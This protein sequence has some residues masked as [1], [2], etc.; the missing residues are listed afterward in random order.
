[1]VKFST[2]EGLFLMRA[3]LTDN[4]WLLYEEVRLTGGFAMAM[5]WKGALAGQFVVSLGGYHPEFEVPAGYPVVPRLG[6]EW[7]ISD[8]I[9]IKGGSYF[10]LTSEALMAGVDVELSANWGWAWV[11]V[12]FGAHAIVFF[13]PFFF[14][15]LAYARISAGIRIKIWFATVS[16]SISIGARIEVEGP[17]FS[18]KATFEIGPCELSVAFGKSDKAKTPPLSWSEF[19][20]KYL[21]DAG[22]DRAR[23]ITGITGRGTRPAATDGARS[24]PS[25]D[26]SSTHPYEVFAEFEITFVTTVPVTRFEAG[27]D[28]V[29]LRPTLSDGTA[30]D[31]GIAPM[32]VSDLG[33][34]MEVTLLRHVPGLNRY[35]LDGGRLAKLADGLGL[36]AAPVPTPHVRADAFPVGVWGPA[37][38]EDQKP[39][40]QG[41]VV[42]AGTSLTLVAG[43]AAAAAGPEIDYRRITSGRRPLPLLVTEAAR[44]ELLDTAGGV[45]VSNPGTPA[46]ALDAART[47]LFA[48]STIPATPGLLARGEHSAVAAA[49]FAG[50]RSAPPRF[51]TLAGGIRRDLAG[52]ATTEP[53]PPREEPTGRTVRAPTVVGLLAAGAGTV[54]EGARTTVADRRRKRRPAPGVES[55]RGRLGDELPIRLDRPAAPARSLDGTLVTT[56]YPRTDLAGVTASHIGRRLGSPH[57]DALVPGLAGGAAPRASS[58]ASTIRSGDLLVLER[59]DAAIDVDGKRPRLMVDGAARVVMLGAAGRVLL[60]TEVS[61]DLVEVPARTRLVGV[62]ADGELDV[63]DGVPGWH[64]RSRLGRLGV[65][66]AAGPGCTV[67]SDA[68]APRRR[69]GWVSGRDLVERATTVCTHFARPADF[70][71]LVL[72]GDEAVGMLPMGLELRGAHRAED[73]SGGEVAPTVVLA[74][75]QSVLLVPVVTEGD[76]LDVV[77]HAGGEWQLGGV[78]ASTGEP[79]DLAERL[80]GGGVDEVAARLLAVAGEG[81]RVQWVPASGPGSRPRRSPPSRRTRPGG[82]Q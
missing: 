25:S 44:V 38:D 5:W 59:P 12:A 20:P 51:G 41:E 74:G 37:Q 29:D 17:D 42:R 81:C 50:D 47:V 45:V 70:V 14:R 62:Q 23:A 4:S 68:A 6:L 22:G 35:V 80:A 49:A 69:T 72:D 79:D 67:I 31:L 36:A 15:A 54:A 16:F 60:D 39:M 56:A 24:A 8:E 52:R 11:R 57:L 61:D 19:V 9:V 7:R 33:S 66:S 28:A 65:G 34:T 1:M 71:V 32:G 77:V 2:S 48:A 43:F 13:D 63:P 55:V 10:A 76:S 21:E 75:A 26:G 78:L 18:G 3:Q 53:L 27:D 58:A 64:A 82:Q 40:P 73:R 30:G 46:A